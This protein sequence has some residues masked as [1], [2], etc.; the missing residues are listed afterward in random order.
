VN[1]GAYKAVDQ[2]EAPINIKGTW[3]PSFV[4]HL[5]IDVDVK[6]QWNEK[7]MIIEFLLSDDCKINNSTLVCIVGE[8]GIGKTSMVHLGSNEERVSDAFDARIF[9]SMP[10]KSDERRR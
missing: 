6:V 4:R 3:L 7:N 2:S 10:E 5:A 9:I 1:E 8:S